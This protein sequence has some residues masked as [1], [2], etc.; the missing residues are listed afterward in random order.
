MVGTAQRRL[1]PPCNSALRLGRRR[2]GKAA[3]RMGLSGLGRLQRGERFLLHGDSLADKTVLHRLGIEISNC[4][5]RREQRL[6]IGNGSL[7]KIEQLMFNRKLRGVMADFFHLL[8][9]V[10]IAPGQPGWPTLQG[11]FG[12]FNATAY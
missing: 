3:G 5:R 8:T 1:C 2:S 7:V 6:P 10:E 9:V 4:G 12:A 11:G